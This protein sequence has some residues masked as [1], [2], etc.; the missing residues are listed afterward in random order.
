MKNITSL[1]PLAA[2]QVRSFRF[3]W[4]ADL[5]TSW[6]MEMETLILGWYILV[7]TG[8]VLLLTLFGSLQFLGTLVAPMFGV[9]GDRVGR[10]AMMCS[11]RAFMTLLAAIIMV[12]GFL[13]I[14]SVIQVFVIAVL[15]GLVRPSDLV[16]RHAL[17]GDTMPGAR[18]AN[19]LGL[20][21]A[22][23]D[24]ARIIGALSGAGLFSFLGIGFAYMAVAAFYLISFAF[25]LGVSAEHPAPEPAAGQTPDHSPDQSPRP[26]RW[27][28]LKDGLRLIRTT[29][30]LLAIMWLAFLVNVTAFPISH[31][32]MPYVAREIYAVDENGLGQLVAGFATSAHAGSIIMAV[33]GGR[34][35]PG[36][37][38]L[39][40]ILGWYACLAV[41]IQFETKNAG[42]AVLMV[43][44]V[45]HSFG[46]ISM[47]VMLL[48][49]VDARYRARVM[50][51]RML[52]VYGLPIGLL[53]SGGLIEWIGFRATAS[54]YISV[55]IVLT[56]V[57]AH[58][59]RAAIWR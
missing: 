23:M 39:F 34:G 59:W 56:L 50:G 54:I 47:T 30:A 52:A 38:A 17:I 9:F 14:L 36:R 45:V 41:F 37:T 43:M 27:A 15:N 42:F 8:S 48:H 16:M 1:G 57:I 7:E 25:T 29:P 3:Q 35:R 58:R 53:A 24:T 13:E 22:T 26:T 5:L 55:G 12:L 31:G 20:S 32:L 11:M 19:A 44:G 2:F 21:R 49:A 46:M 51:V 28:E 33:A 40:G 4:P 6:A 18:L 10:R